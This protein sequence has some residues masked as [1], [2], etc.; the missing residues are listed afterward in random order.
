MFKYLH[1]VYKTDCRGMLVLH[2][3]AGTQTRENSLMLNKEKRIK[4]VI[5]IKLLGY[6]SGKHVEQSTGS[7]SYLSYLTASKEDSTG[8]VKH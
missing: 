4:I 6:E 2:E 8:T 7:R 5:K 3:S 1:G